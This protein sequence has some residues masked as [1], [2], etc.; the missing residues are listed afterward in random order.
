MEILTIES[1]KIMEQ[2]CNR[3]VMSLYSYAMCKCMVR[4]DNDAAKCIEM[5]SETVY[6]IC[7]EESVRT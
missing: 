7:V 1:W 4:H 6:G 3:S 5:L 2:H